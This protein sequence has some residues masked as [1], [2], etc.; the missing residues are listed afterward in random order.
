MTKSAGDNLHYRPPTPNSGDVSP[1]PPVIY[2]HAFVLLVL[3]C[4]RCQCR[5]DAWSTRRSFLSQLQ[6]PLLLLRWNLTNVVDV[7]NFT[8]LISEKHC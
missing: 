3:R 8:N 4:R 1:C 5:L 6:L 7:F 2:A